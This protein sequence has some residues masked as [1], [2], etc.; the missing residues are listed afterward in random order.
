MKYKIAVGAVS[1]RDCWRCRT[2]KSSRFAVGNRSYERIA[3]VEQAMSFYGQQWL[4]PGLTRSL[5]A[6]MCQSRKRISNAV[7]PQAHE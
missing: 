7:I 6:K 1:N 3:I 5:L 2:N 4:S